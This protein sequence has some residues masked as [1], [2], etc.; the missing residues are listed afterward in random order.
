M[1]VLLFLSILLLNEYPPASLNKCSLTAQGVNPIIWAYTLPISN[2]NIE[3]GSTNNILQSTQIRV[4]NA[5]TNITRLRIRTNLT[6][7][8]SD[9]ESNSFKLW[10]NNNN[11]FSTATL[12][13]RQDIVASSTTIDFSGFSQTVNI[14]SNNYFWITVDV[15]ATATLGNQIRMLAYTDIS[16]ITAVPSDI[17]N[18]LI[19]NNNAGIKTIV[20]PPPSISL[21]STNINNNSVLR[22]SEAIVYQYSQAVTLNSAT[23]TTASFTTSGTYVSGDINDFKLYTNTVD[24]FATANLQSTVPPVSSG[25]TFS[26]GAL[27]LATMAGQTRYFWVVA[28]IKTTATLNNDINLSSSLAQQTYLAANK[29]GTLAPAG[30]QKFVDNSTTTLQTINLNSNN[31]LQGTTNHVLYR[32]QISNVGYPAI[33]N[34]L[35]FIT[36]GNYLLSDLVTNSFKLWLSTTNEFNTAN[37]I[38]GNHSIVPSGGNITYSGLNYTINESTTLYFWLTVDIAPQAVGGHTISIG[39]PANDWSSAG[40]SAPFLS[41]VGTANVGGVQTFEEILPDIVLSTPLVVANTVTAGTTQH[42]LYRWKMELSR[43]S[44]ILQNIGFSTVGT[45]QVNDFTN[46]GFQLWYSSND[47]FSGATFI[48]AQPIQASGGNVNFLSLNRTQ[49]TL[50]PH[51][52]WLTVDVDAQA[53]Q[54]HTITISATTNQ[55]SFNRGNISSNLTTA[56]TQTIENPN[57]GSGGEGNILHE[58]L[59][60]TLFTP[61]GDGNN[62]AFILRSQNVLEAQINIYDRFGNLVFST[63]D[64]QILTNIGWDGGNQPSGIYA[65]SAIVIFTDGEHVSQ[66]GQVKLI[67]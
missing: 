47:Q 16:D 62:D 5:P 4:F 29:S 38:G 32:L 53:V 20:L 54:G 12:I 51:Y 19:T 27:G 55:V 14:G 64:L 35:Q 1:K 42:V 50:S 2:G 41:K 6:Y 39:T 44:S 34:Q 22:G 17:S 26:F 56:G 31:V 59:L 45:Y 3:L 11:D 46:A 60:P 25:A 61:N 48:G 23:L 18:A 58:I 30:I 40:I 66:K 13:D 28:S 52:Y 63:Q 57:A 36:Q 37:T 7:I 33:L 10:Y 9:F 49:N 43:N 8:L 65:W 67:K 21:N 24:N 15:S